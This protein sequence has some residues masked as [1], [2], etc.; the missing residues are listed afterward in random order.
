MRRIVP[1]GLL[2]LVAAVSLAAC[3]AAA[4]SHPVSLARKTSTSTLASGGGGG[5]GASS[6]SSDPATAVAA[7]GCPSPAV[8]ARAR[9]VLRAAMARYRI[10]TRGSTI[11]ADLRYIAHDPVLLSALSSGDLAAAHAEIHSLQ[12]SQIVKHITRIRVMKGAHVVIDGWPGSFD[13]AGS[14][15]AL[16]YH[17]RSL[18]QLQITVQDIIGFV[19]LEHD[20]DA[21]ETVARGPHGLLRTWFPAAA[22]TSLP[23]S[24][25]ARV[26]SHRYMVRSFTETA[27]AGEPVTIWLL[28]PA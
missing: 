20:V 23:K 7:R 15:R 28:I 22:R 25:C 6:P 5:A 1:A 2:A 27:F 4:S 9:A 16:R 11:R 26:G 10:E 13:V 24:G 3:G 14:E 19:K 12:H 21:T 17:G 18:G 8:A